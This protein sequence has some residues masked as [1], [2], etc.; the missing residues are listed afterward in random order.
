MKHLTIRNI[1][2]NLAEAIDKERR[3][4]GKSLN[5][6]IIEVLTQSL[7]ANPDVSR[8]NGLSR[9]AGTWTAEEHRRFEADVRSTEQIDPELWE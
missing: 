5:R 8:K 6:T 3:R 2:E 1:P 9:L 4:R 7:G